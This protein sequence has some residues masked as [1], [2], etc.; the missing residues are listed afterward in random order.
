M[1]N[2]SDVFH[3]RAK[4]AVAKLPS[5]QDSDFFKITE[6]D[7]VWK[8]SQ[9][10]GT[11]LRSFSKLGILGIG[12][13]SLGPKV[14][15]DYFGA[16]EKIL[17]LENVDPVSFVRKTKDL[18]LNE[19]HWLVISKSGKTL[20]TLSQLTLLV[21][22]YQEKGFHLST[23]F[24]VIS[25]PGSNPLSDWAGD[26]DVTKLEIPVN[27]GGR[28]SVLSQVGM[29]PVAYLGLDCRGF[30]RGAL[31]IKSEMNLIENLVAQTL[32]SF[33]RG[34]WTTVFWI[35]SDLLSS[36]GGWVQQLWA[37]SLAK[38]TNR[39]GENAM[40]VSTPLPLVGSNDQ[41]SILQQLMDGSRDKFVWFIG[42]DEVES[43][44]L[45]LQ[46]PIGL[47]AYLNG[48]TLGHILKAERVATQKALASVGV[49]TLSLQTRNI[50]CCSLGR[51][52]MTFQCL[53][54]ALAESMDI[55]AFN[56]PGVELGK[57]LAHEMLSSAN[58]TT[59]S[60]AK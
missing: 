27:I 30:L 22:M 52:F 50:S 25:D 8:Q 44:D 51:L 34:E 37:E 19:M 41:H 23:H 15:V 42:I 18:P 40:R 48:Q 4:S 45:K 38:K 2:I 1:P 9:E 26:H 28:F 57:R 59:S 16:N 10:Y 35:Y 58:M 60:I 33:E 46:N 39:L 24:T 36:F 55:N 54:A 5:I 32:A 20:E 43:A 3:K 31:E 13:S 21:K 6:F 14:I 56:Q 17:V 12:G 53:V 11:K 47:P 7:G 29:V 49:S